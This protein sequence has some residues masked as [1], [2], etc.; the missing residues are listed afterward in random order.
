MGAPGELLIGGVGLSRGYLGRPELTAERFVPHASGNVRGGRLYRTGDLA[1][2]RTDGEIEYL[3][4]LDHQV[5]IRGLRVELGEI[6]SLLAE[7]PGV[8]EAAAVVRTEPAGG[9]GLVAF[10]T[11][12]AGETVT[13]EALRE[14]LLRRL[15]E[16][17][18]PS[19]ILVLDALPL[20][21]NGKV[22][23]A[24][25]LGLAQA[26]RSDRSDRSQASSLSS[27]S[28][29]PRTPVEEL[30]ADLFAQVLRVE[31]VGVEESF[32]ELGG[33]S[34]LATQMMSRVRSVFAV[35]LPLRTLFEAPRWNRPGARKERWSLWRRRSSRCRERASRS[36]S[37]SLSSGSGS[38]IS[39]SRD[40]RTTTCRRL[41]FWKARSTPRLSPQ[42]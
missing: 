11:A 16:A 20:T 5:K 15:P 29:T 33:H 26:A 23:R 10:V 1:R 38:S 34:L 22:D 41:C 19:V 14:A 42:R 3:G 9:L 18:V 7:Q 28:G 36:L 39:S 35:E 21:P 6:E 12:L 32:F 27:P 25:L 2:F 4:R 8:R 37:P 40:G 17:L 24:G 13:V 30:V 31:R